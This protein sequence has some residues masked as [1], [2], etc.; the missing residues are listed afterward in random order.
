[1]TAADHDTRLIQVATRLSVAPAGDFVALR[2]EA[3]AEAADR[4]LAAAIRKLRKPVVAAWIVNLLASHDPDALAPAADLADEFREAVDAGDGAALADLARRRRSILRGLVDRA[5]TLAAEAGAD[6]GAAVRS[7][8]EQTL[9]A[10]LRD[11]DAA[12]AVASARLLRPIEATG[13]DAPDLSDAVS[14]PFDVASARPEPTDDLAERR[15]AREAARA[16]AETRRHAES[17]ERDLDR[18]EDRWRAAQERASSL[19]DRLAELDR[20]RA[21]LEDEAERAR[22]EVEDLGEQRRRA[23]AAATKARSAADR[24][25]D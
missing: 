15:A 12:A 13:M 11:P 22:A 23:R 4:E 9:D 7:A 1:M 18:I 16:A 14:G 5:V 25:D 8:V 24:A 6:V 21:R 3:A 10:A 17:L 20:E 2:T 19:E